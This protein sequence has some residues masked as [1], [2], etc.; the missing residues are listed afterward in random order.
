MD[1]HIGPLN[2]VIL[3]SV[4]QIFM[5]EDVVQSLLNIC[6]YIVCFLILTEPHTNQI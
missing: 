1:I 4:E 6:L 5:F 3:V 2:C